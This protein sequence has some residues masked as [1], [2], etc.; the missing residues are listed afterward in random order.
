MEE[1]KKP[2]KNRKLKK[3]RFYKNH[4]ELIYKDIHTLCIEH[5][6]FSSS[7]YNLKRE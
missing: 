5:P 2:I 3:S 4:T 1:E 6:E 7:F